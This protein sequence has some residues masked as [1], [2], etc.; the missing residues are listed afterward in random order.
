MAKTTS[1]VARASAA[2]PASGAYDTTPTTIDTGYAQG[3]ELCVSYTR[4]TT[5][6]AV[7][8]KVQVSQDGTAWYDR[9][10]E[11]GASLSSGAMSCYVA[12]HKLPVSSGSTA[13]LYT[14][15]VDVSTVRYARV[16]AAEYG[17]TGTP[18]TC[19][20]NALFAGA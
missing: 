4:G 11:D 19:A 18:G 5:G 8:L 6:G 10:V 9:T 15:V 12:E 1:F 2:L 3:L 7:K 17:A 16:A 20:I 14:Y 13:E